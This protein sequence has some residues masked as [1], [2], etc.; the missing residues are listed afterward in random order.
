MSANRIIFLKNESVY[1]SIFDNA[2]VGLYVCTLKGELLDVNTALVNILGYSDREKL[3]QNNLSNLMVDPESGTSFPPN[4]DQI[5]TIYFSEMQLERMDGNWIWVR[6][7]LQKIVEENGTTYFIGSVEDITSIKLNELKFAEA[8]A[9]LRTVLDSSVLSFTLIDQDFHILAYNHSAFE[10][11][12]NHFGAEMQEGGSFLTYLPEEVRPRVEN[13]FNSVLGGESIIFDWSITS[14]SGEMEWFEIHIIPARTKDGEIFGITFIAFSKTANKIAEQKM[15]MAFESERKQRQIAE[16]LQEAGLALA[17]SLD[18]SVILDNI[19]EQI[20]PVVPFDTGRVLLIENRK[21]KIARIKSNNERPQL[22]LAKLTGMV[23]DLDSLINLHQILESGQPLVIDDVRKYPGWISV[24]GFEYI[25]SWIGVPIFAQGEI[26]A[27]FSLDKSEPNFY[28]KEH[29]KQLAA[30]AGQTAL[31][32]ENA[33]LFETVQKRAREAD[34]LRLAAA[35]IITELDL[36]HVLD[37]ILVNL[38]KVI[39]YDSAAIFLLEDGRLQT[40]AEKGSPDQQA[41]GQSFSTENELFRQSLTTGRPIIL[42][43]AVDDEHFQNWLGNDQVH[44][45]LGVPLHL[46]GRAIGF[47]TI[48]SVEINAYSTNDSTLV[49]AFAHEATI[50]LENARMFRELQSL[51]TTDPLTQVWNRRHFI[52]LAK[53]EFQRARRYHLPLSAILFDIDSFKSVNDT[54]GHAAGDQVLSKM[55]KL[56]HDN[57]RQV[58]LFGRYGGEEFMALLPNTPIA[59]AQ[60]VAERLRNQ[61]AHTA[62]ETDRGPI[63]IS[64]SFG[65]AEIDETCL[66]IETLLK[67]ADRAAYTAKIEGKN[68]VSLP[69]DDMNLDNYEFSDNK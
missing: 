57:L 8:E 19:L 1:R 23:L 58:D 21:A 33:Q 12:K 9:N 37:R 69:N 13:Y 4:F 35:A 56:C 60:I 66:D 67:R 46:R 40:V 10:T 54:F 27:V 62:M 50:A 3:L 44:G 30:F 29:T 61:I 11:F 51:A 2:P 42:K 16:S 15:Q 17:S 52:H 53:I 22:D 39:H 28:T 38:K 48:G 55:A 64:A 26:I 7:S 59:N 14:S 31:A 20:L 25:R 18:S 47:L 34:M 24:P 5:K 36:D 68:R 6:N 41:L 49:Q 32:L 45:W 43:D 65:V 63:H